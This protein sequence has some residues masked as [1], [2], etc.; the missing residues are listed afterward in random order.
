ML[1]RV[2]EFDVIIVGS[3][4][5][6]SAL[7][8][9][10]GGSSMR[11]AIIEAQALS[12]QWPD[13]KDSVD[14]FDSRVSALTIA[15]QD[16]LQS[17]SVWPAIVEKRVSPYRHMHVWDAEGTGSI[18]F[19]AS[20]INEPFLG[21]IVENRLTVNA[22]VRRMEQC[23]NVQIIDQMRLEKFSSG[24]EGNEIVLADRRVLR[25]PLVVAADG[26]NSQI[27]AQA[28]FVMRE[29][30]YGHK[31]IVATV[32]TSKKH[33]Q[34]A[35]QR[36]LPEGPLAFLPLQS[37]NPDEHLCSIVWSA[38][39][40]YA[41]NLMEQN[42]SEFRQS[43]AAAF[44]YQ[45]GD[46]T[47]ISSRSCFPLK[48]RHAVSYVKTGLALVGD[49]A[50]T[51]HPLAGQGINLGLM[52]VKVLAEELLRAESRGLSPGELTS[53]QRYER[54]RKGSNLA[55]MASM[56]GFKRLFEQRSLPIR[57]ARNTGMHWLNKT[58][59]LKH[60]LMRKAMGL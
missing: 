33:Q 19:S 46:V 10:L 36:F 1:D 55:M 7:A 2:H 49:A 29:W 18:D 17:I 43:L 13:Q 3:G 11:V 16:F 31:A 40:Q 8:C 28:G 21:H 35:W 22:L 57:W 50:H 23:S 27:R 52:D 4:I 47:A 53:L 42:D 44:E 6:G 5:A 56:E 39:P 59:L 41:E 54:R 60:Q 30:E 15:S 20:D 32:Q 58:S 26:A 14:G 51:I 34:T 9:A 45:L 12:T 37:S 38:I 24:D 48:Q 25:A